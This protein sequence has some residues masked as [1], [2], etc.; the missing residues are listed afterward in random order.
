MVRGPYLVQ[1]FLV[2]GGVIS[3]ENRK[4]RPK[5]EWTRDYVFLR[6]LPLRLSFLQ[7]RDTITPVL[8]LC[9][10]SCFFLRRSFRFFDEYEVFFF[11]G[12]LPIRSVFGTVSS[13]T[14]MVL[15]SI[16]M[17]HPFVTIYGFYNLPSLFMWIVPLP[18]NFNFACRLL[19]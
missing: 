4:V 7:E 10:L 16:F 5:S 1:L 18:G 13:V 6:S 19:L 2:G 14:G 17:T 11:L 3:G 15:Y 12:S 8:T 9:L